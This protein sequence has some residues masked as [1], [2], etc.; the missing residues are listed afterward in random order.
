MF[1]MTGLFL[2]AAAGSCTGVALFRHWA[3]RKGLLDIPNERSSHA[4]PTPTGGGL[5]IVLMTLL[6]LIPLYLAWGAA[7]SPTGVLSYLGGAI[8]IGAVSF[9][10]DLRPLSTG[11]RFAVHALGA[12]IAVAGIGYWNAAAMPLLGPVYFGGVGALVTLFW[13][14]ALTNAY[15]FMDGIDGIAG[16][17]AIAAGLGWGILGWHEGQPLVAG[18]GLLIAG[19]SAGFLA[20]NWAPAKIFMGDVGSAFLGYSLAVLPVMFYRAG[21]E[22][23]HAGIPLIAL[24]LVWPFVFDTSFTLL[25]RLGM[26]E[27][28][29]SSHRR[30]LYQRLVQAGCSHR[31]V[32]LGYLALAAAG[33]ALV[34]AGGRAAVGGRVG[35]LLLL[36]FF[37]LGLWIVVKVMERRHGGRQ[38]ALAK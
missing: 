25:R 22:G 20:H 23:A 11:V 24:A 7:V 30:H 27:N 10:D 36:P 6:G 29:L 14:V 5:V 28:V 16:S 21:G 9:R 37:A 26:G 31:G 34:L 35:S 8:L 32:T 4:L 18:L 19:S 12:I 3:R 2:A 1:W 38:S 33:L 17:Q 13:I 15:N